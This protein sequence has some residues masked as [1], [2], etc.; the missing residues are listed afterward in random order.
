MKKQS[1]RLVSFEVRHPVK[2]GLNSN[3]S[4]IIPIF[5]RLSGQKYTRLFNLV[6]TDYYSS[7][8]TYKEQSRFIL[9][10]IKKHLNIKHT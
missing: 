3:D 6:I 10:L 5:Y 8:L 2:H 9:F 7:N 4:A 1:R